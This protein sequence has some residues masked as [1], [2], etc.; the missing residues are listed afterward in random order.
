MFVIAASWEAMAGAAL[1]DRA[2][3]AMSH[4]GVAVTVTSVTDTVAFMVGATTQV[5]ALRWFCIYAAVGVTFV[6]VLQAT[7][8]VAGLVIDQRLKNKGK[9]CFLDKREVDEDK[10]KTNILNQAMNK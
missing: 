9:I 4:A 6:Y 3:K 8:F 1:K 10:K 5:P 7:V 2:F